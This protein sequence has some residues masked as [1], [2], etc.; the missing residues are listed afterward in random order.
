MKN[1]KY[2]LKDHPWM[3]LIVVLITLVFVLAAS[4]IVL[5]GIM[6]MNPDDSINQILPATISNLLLLFVIIPLLFKLPSGNGKLIHYLDDI[7]LVKPKPFLKLMLIGVTCY[8]IFFISQVVGTMIFRVSQGCPIN[9]EFIKN[10]FRVEISVCP[11]L[12]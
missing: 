1:A 2:Q 9:M 10:I 5:F 11:S 8:L 4:S 3:A 12:A 7:G 6:K